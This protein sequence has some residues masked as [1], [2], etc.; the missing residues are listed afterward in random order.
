[1]CTAPKTIN[2]FVERKRSIRAQWRTPA[3]AEAEVMKTA[4]KVAGT[5]LSGNSADVLPK[6]M[7]QR[8]IPPV[9]N[10]EMD[11]PPGQDLCSSQSNE[12][13]KAMSGLTTRADTAATSG[14]VGTTKGPSIVNDQSCG[15]KIAEDK[16]DLQKVDRLL[17]EA[18]DGADVHTE[19]L[20]ATER[21]KSARKDDG[22]CSL[23]VSVLLLG[24]YDSLVVS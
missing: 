17:K 15:N 12:K 20:G 13:R 3:Q 18:L 1:M 4:R 11:T 10:N 5:F 2:V 16:E 6:Q 14:S 22:E 21:S 9:G 24:E 23:S 7:E 8:G 19:V